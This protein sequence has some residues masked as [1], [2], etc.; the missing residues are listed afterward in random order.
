MKSFSLLE[1]NLYIKDQ[2]HQSI[3]DLYWVVAE[4]NELN[5]NG[6]HCYMELI[7]KTA[8]DERITAKARATI[9]AY[10]FKMLQPYFESVTGQCLE[11]G[12]KVMLRVSV[13]FHELYGISLHVSD[14]NPSFTVGELMLQK[15]AILRRLAEEGIIDMNC[16][17]ELPEVIQR[18][19][20]ISS[21]TA[22]GYGDF[23]DQL[24]RNSCGYAFK[25]E[26]FPSIMQGNEAENSIIAA[27]EQIFDREND[28][29]AVVIIRGGGSQSDLNCFNS[30]RLA[31]CIAQF[32]L[33][34]LTGIGHERDSTIADRVACRCLKT[35]TATAEFIIDIAETFHSRLISAS[36]RIALL[37][38]DGYQDTQEHLQQKA[39][40]LQF[41]WKTLMH[42]N[43][44]VLSRYYSD[45]QRKTSMLFIQ[46]RSN[47]TQIEQSLKREI[48]NALRTK[49][50]QI[51]ML[52][53][54]Q[55]ILDPHHLLQRGY[56][57][58]LADGK[59]LRNAKDVKLGQQLKTILHDGKVDSKVISSEL[60]EF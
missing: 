51:K 46:N 14:I 36:N 12:M 5:V 58:T 6:G 18:I 29:D 30:Y 48:Q 27:L 41:A 32:P 60:N 10:H 4:I 56:S 52:E 16:E 43:E 57:I 20:V 55:Q 11:K 26:L 34:I 28:F 49:K 44:K 8:Q 47:L 42:E 54:K 19:A 3:P 39:H 31:S 17:L 9:W 38:R 7:E 37:A 50:E 25:H 24:N 1:L 2:L 13:E 35:P 40:A 53:V 33:P 21:K 23:S 45:F 15:Q 59:I 22:A